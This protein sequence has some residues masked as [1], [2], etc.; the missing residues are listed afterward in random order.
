VSYKHP[1]IESTKELLVMR[2][3]QPYDI[4]KKE[5]PY[6]KGS[7]LWVCPSEEKVPEPEINAEC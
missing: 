6:I 4:D 3:K 7:L 1:T 5:D 2:P